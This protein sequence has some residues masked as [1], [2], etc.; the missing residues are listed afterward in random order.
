MD[1]ETYEMTPL[2]ADI[3]GEDQLPLSGREHGVRGAD[4]H[5]GTVLA[6]ELPFNSSS[7]R[8]SRPSPA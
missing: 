3:V 5:D 7:W 1:M 6:V 4:A 2:S 8:S